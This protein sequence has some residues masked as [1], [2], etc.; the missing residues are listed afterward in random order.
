MKRVDLAAEEAIIET[1]LENDVSF[2]LVSEESGTKQFGATPRECYV[3]IDPIDGPT[4]LVH[5]LPVYCT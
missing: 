1:M 5:G 3:T 2:T 4:N